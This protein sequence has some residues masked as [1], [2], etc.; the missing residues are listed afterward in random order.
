MVLDLCFWYQKCPIWEWGKG[1]FHFLQLPFLTI[2]DRLARTESLVLF[3]WLDRSSGP[4]WLHWLCSFF[5][6]LF[7]RYQTTTFTI[8]NC[9]VDILATLPVQAGM[10]RTSF[11]N[12]IEMLPIR[13]IKLMF[14]VVRRIKIESLLVMCLT[15]LQIENSDSISW[16]CIHLVGKKSTF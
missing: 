9:K 6:Y 7:W 14:Q 16:V 2:S 4:M 5:I 12:T 15:S 11:R 3:C 1:H 10:F 13:S 8:L